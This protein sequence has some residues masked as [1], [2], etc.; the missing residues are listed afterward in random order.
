MN[1]GFQQSFEVGGLMIGEGRP[2]LVVAELGG[3]AGQ[4]IETGHKND[5]RG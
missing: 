3:N 2:A 4:N 1:H 5:R